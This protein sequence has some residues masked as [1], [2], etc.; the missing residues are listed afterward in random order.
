MGFLDGMIGGMVGAALVPV[1][2]NLLA[3]HGGVEGIMNQFETQGLGSTVKTWVQDGPNAPI[4]ADH[5]HKA[6]GE[7]T[8][9]DLAAKAGM[10]PQELAAK[11]A[12]VL[13]HTVDA[14]TPNGAVE[15]K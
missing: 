1:V 7:Q 14:L 11:L 13:P 6:F 4:T 2:N 3:Q 10:S 15:K 8:I 5:V 12:Q 9:N